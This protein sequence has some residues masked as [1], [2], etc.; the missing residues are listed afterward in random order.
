MRR[1]SMQKRAA[2]LTACACLAIASFG[3]SQSV[4]PGWQ[5]VGNLKGVE[6]LRREAAPLNEGVEK[7]KMFEFKIENVSG[8]MCDVK[9]LR[10]NA[11]QQI[12]LDAKGDHSVKYL[13][14]TSPN[15]SA[16]TLTDVQFYHS[17]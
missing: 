4:I 14:G 17:R 10:G 6:V 12:S 7:L 3:G 11:E 13:F 5:V 15:P 1:A 2:I 9:Y 8:R 16:I